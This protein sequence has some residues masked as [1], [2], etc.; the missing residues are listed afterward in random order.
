MPLTP[1]RIG[2]KS[3]KHPTNHQLTNYSDGHMWH[4][5]WNV[6]SKFLSTG[7][8][9]NQV[10]H[11]SSCQV[12]GSVVAVEV[13]SPVLSTPANQK[14]SKI[15]TDLP[16]NLRRTKG[17]RCQTPK[18]DGFPVIRCTTASGAW[19]A[20]DAWDACDV[21]VCGCFGCVGCVTAATA[22]GWHE[23]LAGTKIEPHLHSYKL[24]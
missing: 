16:K 8:L 20:E 9:V 13:V 19:D 12:W 14:T 1:C 6:C 3:C 5:A 11:K 22:S 17:F 18:K 7:P 24:T 21:G 23:N 2:V 10:I 15:Q 4:C